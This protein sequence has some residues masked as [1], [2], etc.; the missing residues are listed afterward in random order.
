VIVDLDF[1][2]GAADLWLDLVPRFTIQDVIENL[3]RVDE[4]QLSC[5]LARHACGLFLLPRPIRFHDRQPMTVEQV[6]RVLTWLKSVFTHV[7]IDISKAYSA[8]DLAALDAAETV[9]LV[10]HLDLPCLRNGRR[11]LEQFDQV[12]GLVSKVRI[13]AN[14]VD[15]NASQFDGHR[16]LE[17]LGQEIWIQVPDDATTMSA[18]RNSGVPLIRQAPR[19]K[20]TRAIVQMADELDRAVDHC[21][22][23]DQRRDVA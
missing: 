21:S 17:I 15:A 20:L 10:T 11:L 3:S 19:A 5:S 12:P 7:I 4:S 2:V 16:A 1:P 9:L 8:L 13:V 6:C 23:L 22:L 18:A 14:R